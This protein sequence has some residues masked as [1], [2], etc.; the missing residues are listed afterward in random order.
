MRHGPGSVVSQ[1]S[2]T[3]LRTGPFPRVEV[4]M[5]SSAS[6]AGQASSGT[7][8]PACPSGTHGAN[9]LLVTGGVNEPK[10]GLSRTGVVSRRL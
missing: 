5:R 1:A 7:R 3:F 2:P 6:T 4:F 10:R 8:H 9:A